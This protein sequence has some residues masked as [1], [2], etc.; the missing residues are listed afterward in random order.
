MIF[1]FNVV[2]NNADIL[3]SGLLITLELSVLIIPIGTVI[4]I[5]VALG[6]TSENHF[7]RK[8]ASIYSDFFRAM[9][10]LVMLIWVYYALPIVTG[11]DI[12]AFETAVIVLSLH[13]SA[14]VG[15][16]IKSGIEAIPKGQVE[17]AKLLG[18]SRFQIMRKIVLPQVF[19]QLLSPL[20][21]LYIEQMKNTTLASVITVNELLH[22]GQILISQTYRPLEIYTII[23]VMFIAI[24]L[25]LVFFSKKFEL[26]AFVRKIEEGTK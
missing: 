16:L 10:F 26:S 1:D 4:G 20:T 2:W 8:I 15:E 18:L 9:P 21:G 12:G 19:R 13:L 14:Y 22:S 6:K 25:P 11:I 23:A 7:A 24:L 3:L 17:A 5:L